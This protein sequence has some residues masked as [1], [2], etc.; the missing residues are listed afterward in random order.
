M[1][2]SHV[3]SCYFWRY[4]AYIAYIAYPFVSCINYLVTNSRVFPMKEDRDNIGESETYFNPNEI[5][6]HL[7]KIR[8]DL[9]DLLRTSSKTNEILRDLSISVRFIGY[10]ALIVI[11]YYISK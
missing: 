9:R 4:L 3:Y 11:I 6:I 1:A 2:S 7:G 8:S 5:E 10:A